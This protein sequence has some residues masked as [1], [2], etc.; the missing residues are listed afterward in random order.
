MIEFA[1]SERASTDYGGLSERWRRRAIAKFDPRLRLKRPRSFYRPQTRP[2]HFCQQGSGK[3][4]GSEGSICQGC[5]AHRAYWRRASMLRSKCVAAKHQPSVSSIASH[6][7]W[8]SPKSLLSTSNATERVFFSVERPSTIGES[9]SSVLAALF[10][11]A[12]QRDWP[13]SSVEA[14][15]CRDGAQL[16]LNLMLPGSF[17]RSWGKRDLR[18]CSL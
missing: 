12:S 3:M 13:P 4:S 5:E 15:R 11:S 6:D 16:K 7:P 18:K 2:V 9:S 10:E 1:K 17:C 8:I 14:P